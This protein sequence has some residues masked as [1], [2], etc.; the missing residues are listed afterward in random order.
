MFSSFV[1][2]VEH[3]VEAQAE[4]NDDKTIPEKKLEEC[5]HN[6]VKHEHLSIQAGSKSKIDKKLNPI[7]IFELIIASS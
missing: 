1:I 5:S 3:D 2:S 4:C 6:T 7:V